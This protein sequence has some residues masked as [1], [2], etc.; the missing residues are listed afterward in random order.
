MSAIAGCT[1]TPKTGKPMADPSYQL[2]LL[3]IPVSDIDRSAE[4]YRDVL[5]FKPQ[6]VAAKYGWAQFSAG[7]LPLAL[8][9]PGKGGGDGKIGGSTGFH[10]DLPA[11]QFDTLAADLLKRGVLVDNRIQR[12]DDGSTYV[13]VRD[14]DGNVLNIGRAVAG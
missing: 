14:L 8:Y 1:P 2:S 11:E 5:K 4:F 12:G 6:F 9:K 7:D 3:K 10:L 13:Q